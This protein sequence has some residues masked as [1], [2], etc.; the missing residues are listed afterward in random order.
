MNQD[1][2]ARMLGER[3]LA[4]VDVDDAELADYPALAEAVRKGE[5]IPFVLVGEEVKT[6]SS[7]GIYWIEEQL[8]SLGVD[9]Y[10]RSAAAGTVAGGD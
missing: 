6:P 2:A 9:T 7:I 3:P 1:L 4:Y 8:E 5:R 10:A